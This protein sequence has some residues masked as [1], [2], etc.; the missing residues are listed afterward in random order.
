MPVLP[1][2]ETKVTHGTGFMPTS[3]RH[4]ARP[5]GFNEIRTWE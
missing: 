1:A 3:H 5:T 4:N 2:S